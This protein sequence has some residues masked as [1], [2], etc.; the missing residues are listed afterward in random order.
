MRLP[1]F[2]AASS[3]MKGDMFVRAYDGVNGKPSTL[4][5]IE[6]Q[7]VG[8]RAGGFISLTGIRT[9]P[10]NS[11][12]SAN[13]KTPPRSYL[14]PENMMV[15]VLFHELVHVPSCL[16]ETTHKVRITR[17]WYLGYIEEDKPN[18]KK[19]PLVRSRDAMHFTETRARMLALLYEGR[20]VP[21]KK[22]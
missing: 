2:I 5:L 6:V 21:V 19:P 7:D 4:A 10:E 14:V 15:L 20:A 3:L 13:V 9:V 1:T 16:I 8:E 17:D 11:E 12:S 22:P 18:P